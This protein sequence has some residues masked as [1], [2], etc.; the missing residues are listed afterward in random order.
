MKLYLSGP[1]TGYPDYNRPAFHATAAY[2]RMLGYEVESPAELEGDDSAPW[3]TWMRKALALM[4]TCEAVVFLPGW[5]DSRG[6]WL[7]Y[8]VA[9]QLGMQRYAFVRDRL[10]PMQ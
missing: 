8:Q 5:R 9:T 3:E 1:M 7:E 2:L 6:A 10:I 4:L